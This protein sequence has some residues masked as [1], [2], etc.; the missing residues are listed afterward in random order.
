MTEKMVTRC[1]HCRTAFRIYPHQ[2]EQRRGTVRCGACGGIFDAR[3]HLRVLTGAQGPPSLPAS[4]GPP[5]I[6]MPG[7][8]GTRSN[9]PSPGAMKTPAPPAPPAAVSRPAA[10]PAAAAATRPA[11]S[12]SK[13]PDLDFS[14]TRPQPVAAPRQ[15]AQLEARLDAERD[16]LR[17]ALRQAEREGRLEAERAARREMERDALREAERAGR[18]ERE[19]Q[20]REEAERHVLEEAE[21]ASRREA[22]RARRWESEQA[23]RR[24]AEQASRREAEQRSRV[25]AEQASRR[26]AD[27]ASRH[28][29]ASGN[30]IDGTGGID[31]ERAG[32][33]ESAHAPGSQSEPAG[34]LGPDPTNRVEATRAAWPDAQRSIPVEAERIR[35]VPGE[36]PSLGER[37]RVERQQ[38]TEPPGKVDSPLRAE[39]DPVTRPMGAPDIAHEASRD[40]DISFHRYERSGTPVQT[41][42]ER[43]AANESAGREGP[44]DAQN[45]RRDDHPTREAEH[46]V[47]D[48]EHPVHDAEH[49]VH[50]AEHPVHDAEHPVHEAEHPVH[51]AEPHLDGD[52]H[53]DIG[54]EAETVDGVLLAAPPRIEQRAE[55]P[56][57]VYEAE[58]LVKPRRKRRLLPDDFE[59]AARAREARPALRAAG[60]VALG[61]LLLFQSALWFRSDIAG[62]YPEARSA[63]NELCRP[64]HC[65]VQWPRKI[66]DLVID[67]SDLRAEDGVLTLTATLRNRGSLMLALPTIELTITDDRGDPLSLRRLKPAD[68]LGE[69]LAGTDG[70]AAGT[71]LSLTVYIDA[72]QLA[73]SGYR[74]LVLYA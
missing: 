5:S 21:R 49:P 46:P 48:A 10:A 63:L 33:G 23:S 60:T 17:D 16:A 30:H 59:F 35:P 54:D 28:E 61:A 29:G 73:A 24:E 26:E 34:R 56:V 37:P 7:A 67:A 47:R 4:Q 65:D 13:L 70:I 52:A 42:A 43:D 15:A 8:P 53:H 25:E 72:S 32:G 55:V 50:E 18:I 41:R 20:L 6:A 3:Q 9:T 2:I 36:R 27:P 22:E 19:R 64:F 14:T 44:V 45:T 68:Y 71:E 57:R 1:P 31:F 62:H 69:R 58:R 74:L 39:T 38:T 11:A 66:D 12:H 40:T 51:E